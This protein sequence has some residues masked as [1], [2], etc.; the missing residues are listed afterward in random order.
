[1]SHHRERAILP[2]MTSEE[3]FP[4]SE[5]KIDVGR[6][7]GVS[8]KPEGELRE[9]KP[10]GELRAGKPDES[11]E[12]GPERGCQ[13]SPENRE[14]KKQE[15]GKPPTKTGGD[16]IAEMVFSCTDDL[17]HSGY[18]VCETNENINSHLKGNQKYKEDLRQINQLGD[19]S[20]MVR[21]QI[22]VKHDLRQHE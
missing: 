19:V 14:T 18:D 10:E 2:E 8:E 16:W 5:T 15:R 3:E 6:R 17:R 20:T 9:E 4:G 12:R 11:C 13:K 22:G 21:D 1:M 7:V